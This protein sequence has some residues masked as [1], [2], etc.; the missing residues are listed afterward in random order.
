MPQNW[1]FFLTIFICAPD[2]ENSFWNFIKV[3]QWTTT[4]L[5]L[6]WYRIDCLITGS[7]LNTLTVCGR[8][9]DRQTDLWNCYNS[10]AMLTFDKNVLYTCYWMW[11]VLLCYTETKIFTRTALF[12]ATY[13]T[14]FYSEN[15]CTTIPAAELDCPITKIGFEDHTWHRI[16]FH[17]AMQ[18]MHSTLYMQIRRMC[19]TEG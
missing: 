8:Q 4:V 3:F 19:E 14:L 1:Q 15:T 7:V 10:I 12:L 9:T 5:E 18:I 13:N 11:H 17:S 16:S 6:T 2:G